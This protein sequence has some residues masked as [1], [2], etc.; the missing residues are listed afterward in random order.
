MFHVLEY[1]GIGELVAIG[2]E[3]VRSVENLVVEKL[4]ELRQYYRKSCVGRELLL[5]EFK[6]RA[7]CP[8]MWSSISDGSINMS[9][10]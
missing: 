8:A 7:A 4:E 2:S 1:L 10:V 6:V 3:L 9:Q 5:C